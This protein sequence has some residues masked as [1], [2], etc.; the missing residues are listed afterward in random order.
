[1]RNSRVVFTKNGYIAFDTDSG[2]ILFMKLD[3]GAVK[4]WYSMLDL[5]KKL[6]NFRNGG[7]L[8]GESVDS[9]HVLNQRQK[10]YRETADEIFKIEYDVNC[11]YIHFLF[12]LK[13]GLFKHW[14]KDGKV[15]YFEF[16]RGKGSNEGERVVIETNEKN[17]S[18][19]FLVGSF[20][21]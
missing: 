7:L 14:H 12:N 1:M 18:Y 4:Q 3:S 16:W 6:S 13:S 8:E 17:S 10:Y 2:E 11:G 20:T 15:I 19:D 5:R 21:S 9:D